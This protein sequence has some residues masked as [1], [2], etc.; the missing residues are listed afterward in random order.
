MKVIWIVTILILLFIESSEAKS[1]C[2]PGQYHV[3]AHFRREYSRLDGTIVKAA[4]V[5]AHCRPLSKAYE[6]AISRF[7]NGAPP[8]WPH[9]TERTA[10]WTESEKEQLI[11]ALEGLPD[12]ILS[13]K[14]EKFY[15]L[16][17]S[18]DYPN[19]A[20]SSDGVVVVY[21]SIF[22]T[23]RNLER[24][25][26]HELIHQNFIDQ[27]KEVQQ[28]YRRVA[29]WSLKLT[30]D[31]NIYWFGRSDG[32]VQDDG[33]NSFEEDYANNLEYYLFES[34]KLKKLTPGVYDWIRNH[35]G[36]SFQ[37]KRKKQ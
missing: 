32:Y 15:R 7:M 9:K 8:N 6:Y 37:L 26:A 21:D 29:G 27:A 16:R 18:E 1:I 24:I 14:I 2:P 3:K 17:K 30:D 13:R 5:K 35:F 36:E 10:L 4:N 11:E 22:D 12:I 25:L 31:R 34:D 28:D 19:P 33:K 23:S 20:S